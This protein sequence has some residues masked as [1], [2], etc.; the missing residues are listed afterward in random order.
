MKISL[1]WLRD[2]VEIPKDIDTKN[3]AHLFTLR[4]AEVEGVHDRAE[5]FANMVVGQIMEIHP[6]PNADKLKITKT[7]VGKQ[8][9]QIICG[10][11]NIYEG[12]YVAVALPGS[13]VRWHG[14]G[15]LVTL[16]PAKIRGE[17]SFG[18]ICAASE[19]GLE[20]KTDGIL[21]LSALKPAVGEALAQALG[22]DDVIMVIDNKSL[23]HRPDLWGHYG[24]ARELAAIL[25]KKLKPFASKISYPAKNTKLKIEVKE[26]TLCP[27]YLGVLI[28]NVKIEES[29]AWLKKRLSDIGYRPIS[30]IVDLTN[31]VMAELGQPMHAFDADKIKGGIVVRRAKPEETITTLDGAARKLDYDAL[32]IADREKAVAIAGIMGGANSEI[33][34]STTRII[35][36]SANFNPSNVRKTSARLGIRTEAVQR[37]EKSLDPVLAEQAMDRLCEM[38]LQI[39]PS[40]KIIS[41]KVDVKNFAP[42]KI[43]ITIDPKKIC[44]KIGK[45]IPESEII[46]ILTKLEFKAE[47]ST[48]GKIKVGV[49]S[50]RA[51]KDVSLEDD[52]VE[53]IARIHGYENIPNTLPILPTLLPKENIERTLKHHARQIF[54]YGLGFNEVYNYSFYNLNDI[55]QAL[56]PEEIHLKIENY[57]SEDQTHMRVSLLP[58]ILKNAAYNLK[59]RDEFKLYEIGRTYEDLGEYFPLEEKKI[60]AL[61]VKNKNFKG[62]VFYEAKG[63]LE[64]FIAQLKIKGLRMRKGESFCPYAHPNK[65]AEYVL[66]S[67]S[68]EEP[69]RVIANIF[70]LHPLA[71][72]NFELG[73]VKIGVIEIN[74]TRLLP[75]RK[76]EASYKTIPKFP[77]I[78]L[79]VSFLIDH[80]KE[81]GSLQKLITNSGRALIKEVKLFDIYQGPNIPAGQKS[82]AFKIILQ[83]PDRTLTDAEMKEVQAKIFDEIKKA[84]GA[85]RGL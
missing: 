27:R 43:S 46:N 33:S 78:A 59:F 63:A 44:S 69:D 4:T 56:L 65:Y 7:S 10:A 66:T 38:I 30:N 9:L 32:V 39:C 12:Q 31:Y 47:K 79:D 19:I 2:F 13:K 35:I 29:P 76:T 51:A 48:K 23:T 82:L 36:E 80:K 75:L 61:I 49:P 70:E 73:D 42:A 5:E 37:F 18:M 16:E 22:K 6:H 11:T 24:I 60:C 21:D 1:N 17:E 15:E 83:A 14:E 85:V 77:E 34:D 52:L 53:E 57:L 55:K 41:G 62:E 64:K 58:G 74:F 68:E 54:S 8:T 20:D 28:E 25:D 40:A 26:P 72:K 45:E 50:F 81:V 67:Q 3:L 71:A 84:G